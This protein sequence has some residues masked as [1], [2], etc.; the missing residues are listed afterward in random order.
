[1]LS[2]A[3]FRIVSLIYIYIQLLELKGYTY[4]IR[5]IN[6]FAPK[7][8]NG[9]SIFLMFKRDR[10][11]IPT[12]FTMFDFVEQH[13]NTFLILRLYKVLTHYVEGWY[14]SMSFNISVSVKKR[15]KTIDIL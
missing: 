10:M 11:L 2:K 15:R 14:L 6:S 8:H 1:M 5:Y 3:Q 13:L 9:N 7:P 12:H 4:I